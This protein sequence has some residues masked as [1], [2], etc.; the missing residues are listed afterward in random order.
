[1]VRRMK[2]DVEIHNLL[3]S[4]PLKKGERSLLLGLIC[5]SIHMEFPLRNDLCTVKIARVPGNTDA[6]QNW[7]IAS[8]NTFILNKFKTAKYYKLRGWLPVVL[9][10]SKRLATLIRRYLRQRPDATY[11]L[12][13][14]D[15]R[16]YTKSGFANLFKYAPQRYLNKQ[17]GTSMFR[18]IFLTHFLESDPP[19][20]VKRLVMR[21][22]LQVRLVTQDTYRRR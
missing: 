13:R 16:P 9:S 8:N 18:K 4:K 21:K 22:M 14:A 17:I 2:R 3:K 12:E 15:G 6:K 5:W 10:P 20:K 11:L 19:L 1:M 7:Y